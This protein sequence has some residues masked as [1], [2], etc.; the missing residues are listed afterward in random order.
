MA[1]RGQ[2]IPGIASGAV[3]N[4]TIAKIS[5]TSTINN[6]QFTTCNGVGTDQPIGVIEYD[7]ATGLSCAVVVDGV[8]KVRAGAAIAL[9]ATGRTP[10]TND[11]SGRAILAAP[12]V[13]VNLG[14]L[15]YAMEPAGALGDEID[16]LV[17]P[18]VL[19]G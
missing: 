19:Q 13:G 11:A 5:S 16:V 10:I 3:V 7:A 6:K 4:R 17:N 2:T 18:S 1:Q 15:G 9:A 14:I 8:C 12:G